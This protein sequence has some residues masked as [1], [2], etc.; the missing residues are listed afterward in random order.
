VICCSSGKDDTD[1][2]GMIE[3]VLDPSVNKTGDTW[4]I[5]VEVVSYTEELL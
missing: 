1:D 4:H 3:L 5:C 2:D